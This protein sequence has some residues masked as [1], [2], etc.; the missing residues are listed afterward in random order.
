MKMIIQ[1]AVEMTMLLQVLGM[2][3][4]R[5]LFMRAVGLRRVRRQQTEQ[6]HNHRAT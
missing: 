2:L 6:S 1:I 3:E 4:R 5:H